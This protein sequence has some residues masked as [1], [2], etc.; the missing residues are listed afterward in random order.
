[1]LT[2][3]YGKIDYRILA[4]GILGYRRAKEGHMVLYPH[5]KLVL[6]GL[7]RRGLRMAIVSDAPRMSVWMRLISLGLD[8]YFDTVVS[9]DD[10]G[11][12]KPASLT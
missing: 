12:R 5:V 8:T 9:L 2:E 4:A 6:A 3:E 10:T 1:M 11:K 7:L